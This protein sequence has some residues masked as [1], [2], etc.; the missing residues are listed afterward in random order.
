[1]NEHTHGRWRLSGDTCSDTDMNTDREKDRQTDYSGMFLSIKKGCLDIGN[2]EI[3][4]KTM[5]NEI[6]QNT[7]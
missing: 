6:S 7:V 4:L 5:L 2:N 1:M 3:N